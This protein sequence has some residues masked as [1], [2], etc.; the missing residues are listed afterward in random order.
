MLPPWSLGPTPL[1]GAPEVH[2]WCRVA[3]IGF[4]LNLRANRLV[5]L[6][7]NHC[8]CL[9]NQQLLSDPMTT[10]QRLSKKTR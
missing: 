2:L 1:H 8:N 3:A 9:L 4:L 10:A 5:M 7:S 6:S